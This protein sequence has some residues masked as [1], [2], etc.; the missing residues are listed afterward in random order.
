MKAAQ[1][2]S[3]A[4]QAEDEVKVVV[5]GKA[6]GEG[7]SGTIAAVNGEGDGSHLSSTIIQVGCCAARHHSR[8]ASLALWCHWSTPAL[9]WTLCSAYAEDYYALAMHNGDGAAQGAWDN[10]LRLATDT[11]MAGPQATPNGAEPP[12]GAYVR[13]CT[14]DLMAAALKCGPQNLSDF[15]KVLQSR[16][17]CC[18]PAACNRLWMSFI[19]NLACDS[20]GEGLQRRA[21]LAHVPERLLAKVRWFM[22]QGWLGGALDSRASAGG[23]HQRSSARRGG[24]GAAAAEAAG[25]AAGRLR[26]QLPGRRPAGHARLPA[27]PVA[28]RSS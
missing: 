21:L 12:D 14:L 8:P 13:R 10:I 23:S 9:G 24:A 28:G 17:D 26:E 7:G 25:R 4:A 3:K 15:M 2:V 19:D 27:A 16:C 11:S 18:D 6:S 20:L 1:A 22:V 5:N